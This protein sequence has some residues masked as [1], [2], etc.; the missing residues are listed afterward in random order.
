MSRL[1]ESFKKLFLISQILLIFPLKLDENGFYRSSWLTT[2]CSA[3]LLFLFCGT[4]YGFIR[5]PLYTT[6]ASLADLV[7]AIQQLS[8]MVSLILSFVCYSLSTNRLTVVLQDLK[9]ID[10][11]LFDY[12]A[13]F[14]KCVSFKNTWLYGIFAVVVGV[15][16]ELA[17]QDEV[18][19]TF[20]L[21]WTF[22]LTL[23]FK[24][25][26]RRI[27]EPQAP[28]IDDSRQTNQDLQAAVGVRRHGK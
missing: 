1:E 21:Y 2:C 8:M 3:H 23:D 28:S 10:S 7:L 4:I 14:D 26:S 20:L 15:M 9:G 17:Y 24:P 12:F 11:L 25:T 18:F 13:K 19:S 5:K 16:D 6:G 27:D 22:F